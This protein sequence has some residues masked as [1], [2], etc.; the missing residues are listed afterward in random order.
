MS[1]PKCPHCK[2]EFDSEEIYMTGSTIFP[3][4]NDGDE[5]ETKCHNC[6]KELRIEL[7]LQP[8]WNFLDEDGD[9]I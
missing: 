9:V 2:Y 8:Q 1:N 7:D 6:D 5:T 3:T 4:E